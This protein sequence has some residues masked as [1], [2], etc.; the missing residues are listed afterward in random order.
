M[1]E[2]VY[3]ARSQA[4]VAEKLPEAQWQNKKGERVSK[5]MSVGEKVEYKVTYPDH[6]LYV[7]EVGNNTCQKEDGNKGCEKYLALRGT[8]S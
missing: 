3:K 2:L 1:Y 6:I 8:Q 5:E 7:D 4:G